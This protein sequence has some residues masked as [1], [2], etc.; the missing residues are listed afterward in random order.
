MSVLHLRATVICLHGGSVLS[1]E[2]CRGAAKMVKYKEREKA[3]ER[4]DED[5]RRT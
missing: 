5:G 4:P 1:V 2:S 3:R